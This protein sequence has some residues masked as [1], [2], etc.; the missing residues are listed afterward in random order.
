LEKDYY[1]WRRIKMGLK[2]LELREYDDIWD[3]IGQEG[4]NEEV[5]EEI[6]CPLDDYDSGND[7]LVEV[8]EDKLNVGVKG[9]RKYLV[10]E[11]DNE[12]VLIILY[13]QTVDKWKEKMKYSISIAEFKLLED[14]IKKEIKNIKNKDKK[15]SLKSLFDKIFKT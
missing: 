3:A 10:Y 7:V 8:L 9:P 5:E 13:E 1:W 15:K 11:T 4:Y 14:L 2:I 6:G 12:N